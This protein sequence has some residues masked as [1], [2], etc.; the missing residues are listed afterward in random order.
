MWVLEHEQLS[1][2]CKGNLD[3]QIKITCIFLDNGKNIICQDRTQAEQVQ[4][5]TRT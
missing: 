2:I 3:L 1:L 4:H 5:A